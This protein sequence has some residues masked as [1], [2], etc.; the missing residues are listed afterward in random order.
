MRILFAMLLISSFVI[1]A[2]HK[3]VCFLLHK[4]GA[5]SRLC[6]KLVRDLHE[7]LRRL[8]LARIAD[9]G[10]ERKLPGWQNRQPPDHPFHAQKHRLCGANSLILHSLGRDCKKNFKNLSNY[11]RE[12][13]SARFARKRAISGGSGRMRRFAQ[14]CVRSL[15]NPTFFALF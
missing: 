2:V 3:A 13:C 6:A 10:S 9:V 4:A 1:G 7:L 14:F 8:T 15:R 5:A 11:F 12:R